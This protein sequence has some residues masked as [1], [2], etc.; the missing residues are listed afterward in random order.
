VASGPCCDR[1]V[2]H[3]YEDEYE[4]EYEDEYEHEY[5][6]EYEYELGAIA[7][8]CFPCGR[9]SSLHSSPPR[10]LTLPLPGGGDPR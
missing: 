7:S 1:G 6:D 8:L 3:E 5:E 4:H 2:E 9:P 10:T